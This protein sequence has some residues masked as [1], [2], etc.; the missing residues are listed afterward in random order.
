[1]HRNCQI[2]VYNSCF[3]RF[4]PSGYAPMV[5]TKFSLPPQS[6]QLIIEHVV[7]NKSD[8]LPLGTPAASPG[9]CWF[10]WGGAT[11]AGHHICS[12]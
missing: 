12:C 1:M 3:S 11:S 8:Q 10:L 5:T 4:Q 9:D 2:Y 7:L 6:S